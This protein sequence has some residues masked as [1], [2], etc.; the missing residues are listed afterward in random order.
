MTETSDEAAIRRNLD[1]RM[2]KAIGSADSSPAK[3][4]S[5]GKPSTKESEL[6]SELASWKEWFANGGNQED[7]AD[8]MQGTEDGDGPTRHPRPGE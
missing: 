1:D 3:S 8:E 4:I 5:P 7:V 6:A 2:A